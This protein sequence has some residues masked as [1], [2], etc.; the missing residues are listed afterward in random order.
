MHI[1]HKSLSPL[2]T[3]VEST[4]ENL[5]LKIIYL[6]LF[7]WQNTF[8]YHKDNRYSHRYSLNRE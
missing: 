6:N 4:A 2:T 8:I 5:E 7:A 1:E 3:E